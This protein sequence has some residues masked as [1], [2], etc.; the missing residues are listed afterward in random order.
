MVFRPAIT[1][2]TQIC[3]K[4]ILSQGSF[5]ALLWLS[6]GCFFYGLSVGMNVSNFGI[7]LYH[8]N[9]QANIISDILSFEII[10]NIVAAP[11][12]LILCIKCGMFRLLAISLIIRNVFLVL[13]G[14]SDNVL[15][16]KISMFGFGVGGFILYVLIFQWVNRLASN[17]KRATYISIASMAFGLGI[18]FGPFL[19]AYLEMPSNI[20]F[21]ISA[22]LSTVM[23]AFVIIAKQYEP[24]VFPFRK[25]TLYKLFIFAQIPV[26]CAIASEY[27]YFGISDFLPL[28]LINLGKIKQDAYTLLGYFSLSGILLSIPMGI[29]CDRFDRTKLTIVIAVIMICAIEILP[30]VIDNFFLT[31]IIFTLLSASLNALIVVTLAIL[32]DK[33]VGD[34]L[35][36][37]GSM[38][39][40][41]STI[42]GYAG[43]TITG[44]IMHRLGTDGF[45]FSFSSL[46]LVFLVL[47][48]WESYKHK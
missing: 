16:F 10:G 31:L 40:A 37:A 36:A 20:N 41:M 15:L 47:L 35:L 22:I 13:F 45:I 14:V 30:M 48:L 19:T 43:I 5:K 21:N 34:D 33:F 2:R 32:G 11:F 25:M 23:L 46:F 17:E 44:N 1:L 12:V 42:G 3:L 38:V 6:L 18:A 28:F 7:F 27:A 4:E 9:L 39:H 24:V 8:N 29:I 26:M